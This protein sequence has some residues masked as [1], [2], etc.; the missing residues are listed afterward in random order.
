MQAP[1]I[2]TR[3]C[4]SFSAAPTS[5]SCMRHAPARPLPGIKQAELRTAGQA[6]AGLLDVFALLPMLQVI[7]QNIAGCCAAHD[8]NT[9]TV[10]QSPGFDETSSTH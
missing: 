9:F 10:C 5:T 6:E 8:D 7:Q 3:H 2:A 1:W 4:G